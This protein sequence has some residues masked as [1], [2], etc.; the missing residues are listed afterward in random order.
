MFIH[1]LPGGELPAAL[2]T[3]TDGGRLCLEVQQRAT[4][5]AFQVFVQNL[6]VLKSLAATL[7]LKMFVVVVHV[8]VQL[9]FRAVGLEADLTAELIPVMLGEQLLLPGVR[10]ADLDPVK[11][12]YWFR[13]RFVQKD[14]PG[15]ILKG[16][17]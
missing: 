17:N 8:A 16:Q 7:A 1:L 10:V 9:L 6:F 12:Q 5:S 4:R 15:Y 14:G 11:C 2:V 3:Y 13:I